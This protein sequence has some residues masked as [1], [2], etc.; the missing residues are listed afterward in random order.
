MISSKIL[1]QSA[2]AGL[3][4]GAILT[5]PLFVFS[6]EDSSLHLTP[7]PTKVVFEKA[8]AGVSQGATHYD[9]PVLRA[10]PAPGQTHRSDRRIGS[11]RSSDQPDRRSIEERNRAANQALE[12]IGTAVGYAEPDRSAHLRIHRV[13][14]NQVRTVNPEATGLRVNTKVLDLNR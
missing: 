8:D 12:E 13:L 9:P 3:M 2:A 6:P 7:S 14:A 1:V 10:A 4:A 11:A 5:S